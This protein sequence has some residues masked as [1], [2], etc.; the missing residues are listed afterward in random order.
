M[1]RRIGKICL[2][3]LVFILSTGMAHANALKFVVT[4]A[5]ALGVDKGRNGPSNTKSKA[6][7]A[8][9]INNASKAELKTLQGVD[10]AL[11]AKIIAGRP[12]PSKA[13]LVTHNIIP[14]GL[15]LQLK[16]RIIAKQK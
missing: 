8:V 11:A 13:N 14:A 1:T 7:K 16:Q 2:V 15:Y 4:D 3:T 6:D 5:P 10:D 9:D 12:Y